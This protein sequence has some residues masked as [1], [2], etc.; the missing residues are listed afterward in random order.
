[1][2]ESKT[3]PTS[4]FFWELWVD[5]RDIADT[6]EQTAEAQLIAIAAAEKKLIVMTKYT[7]IPGGYAYIYRIGKKLYCVKKYGEK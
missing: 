2:I 1:M 5:A 3:K 6:D 4:R 7:A